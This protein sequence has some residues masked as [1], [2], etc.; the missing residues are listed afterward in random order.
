M[1]TLVVAQIHSTRAGCAAGPWRRVQGNG[2]S[3]PFVELEG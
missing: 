2:R 3:G 1:A